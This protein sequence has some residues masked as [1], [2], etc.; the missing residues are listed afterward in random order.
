MIPQ[1]Q[2]ATDDHLSHAAFD[3]GFERNLVRSVS[4]YLL[5][6][7]CWLYNRG[8]I[9]TADR[10]AIYLSFWQ[11]HVLVPRRSYR[12]S[13]PYLLGS[14]RLDYHHLHHG[15][16]R[17]C[18]QRFYTQ[19]RYLHDTAVLLMVQHHNWSHCL[20]DSLRDQYISTSRQDYRNWP[21]YSEQ[22]QHCVVFRITISL[23]SR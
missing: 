14:F 6:A 5:H 20:Y 3:S 15:W 7:A 1:K 11:C 8:V 4:Q 19:R 10:S 17:S 22:S 21:C 12:T 13:Q 9:Q 23:Q 2:P 16:P 18:R